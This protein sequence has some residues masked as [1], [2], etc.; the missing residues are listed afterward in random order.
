MT[1]TVIHGMFTVERRYK[2][3][4]ARVFAAFATEEGK[5]AWF[6]GPNDDWD[7]LD[8]AFDF[9]VGGKERLSGRW[10]TARSRKCSADTST[11]SQIGASFTSTRWSSTA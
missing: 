2:A 11:S 1:E 6:S 9:R 5:Q 10:K 4:P 3:A 7:L 8:R